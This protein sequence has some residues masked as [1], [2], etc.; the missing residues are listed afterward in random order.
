MGP[1]L[2]SFLGMGQLTV[3]IRYHAP[4]RLKDLGSRKALAEHCRQEIARGLALALTGRSDEPE[5]E[6]GTATLAAQ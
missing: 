6:A 5:A 2:W 3:A 1:H 4:V